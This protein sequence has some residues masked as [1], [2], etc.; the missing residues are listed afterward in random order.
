MWRT[1]VSQKS[2]FHLRTQVLSSAT[3]TDIFF[4][5]NDSYLIHP[6]S[7]KSV[8]FQS[9]G[10]VPWKKSL[11]QLAIELQK[12]SVLFFWE[13]MHYT[14]F[15]FVTQD[16]QKMYQ[17]YFS[18]VNIFSLLHQCVLKWNWLLFVSAWQWETMRTATVW[19]RFD[20]CQSAIGSTHH[21]IRT[22]GESMS[23]DSKVFQ[24]LRYFRTTVARSLHQRRSWMISWCWYQRNRNKAV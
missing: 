23:Q 7:C 19:C 9:K 14:Y 10:G 2:N 24:G 17:R 3:N 11:V 18:E 21:Y 22:V 15:P 8:S 6:Q 12:C 16:I 4:P 1:Q 20:L 13:E 5:C